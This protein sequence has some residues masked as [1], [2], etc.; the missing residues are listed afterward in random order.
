MME[1]RLAEVASRPPSGPPLT[2]CL[3]LTTTYLDLVMVLDPAT[4]VMKVFTWET[5]GLPYFT[6]LISVLVTMVSMVDV[7]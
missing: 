7:L 6:T 4:T 1:S 3:P 2:K 5:R